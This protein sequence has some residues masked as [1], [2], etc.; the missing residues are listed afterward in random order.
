MRRL[1]GLAVLV[2]LAGCSKPLPAT[3][4]ISHW[5]ESGPHADVAFDGFATAEVTAAENKAGQWQCGLLFHSDRG[6]PWRIYWTSLDEG[7]LGLWG[8]VGGSSWGTDSPEG[9]I[10]AMVRVT[11]DGR[12]ATT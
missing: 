4:C 3:D 10:E 12:L 8:T 9:P 1:I 11:L 2:L 7:T 5:N 6:E